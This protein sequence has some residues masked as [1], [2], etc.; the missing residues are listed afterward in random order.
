MARFVVGRP[1]DGR[2]MNGRHYV[3]RERRFDE[4]AAWF[5]DAKLW[6]EKW[7]GGR[8]AERDDH[9]GFDQR[10]L[11]LEPGTTSGNLSRIRF[12][13]NAA[14]A[15]R[16]PFEMFDDVGDVGLFA[17][18]AGISERIVEKLAGRTNE[19][20]A[21]QIFFVAGLLADKQYVRASRAFA[22]NGLR[23]FFPEIAG[24]AIGG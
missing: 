23:S 21:G 7:L 19:R 17:I 9:L 11:G 2:G 22:E 8:S 6:T 18:D 24:F 12:L 16:L 4:L 15:T 13:V 20:F 1:Q 5:G 3:R 10:E 14:F